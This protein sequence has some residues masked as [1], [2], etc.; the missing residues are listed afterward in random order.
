MLITLRYVFTWLPQELILGTK[1]P[2]CTSKDGGG[3]A[4][5]LK[6][7]GERLY[8]SSAPV[9]EPGGPMLIRALS[10]PAPPGSASVMAAPAPPRP[11]PCSLHCSLHC[12]P[13]SAP[14]APTSADRWVVSSVF[15]SCLSPCPAHGIAPPYLKSRFFL[16]QH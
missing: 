15:S 9:I 13:L 3:G 16:I 8:Q 10:P 4:K 12:E 14:P 11:R 1:T 6:P 5:S 2:Y 7:S